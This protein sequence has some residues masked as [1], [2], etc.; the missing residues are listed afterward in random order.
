[1]AFW[2]Q[3]NRQ[4]L[5]LKHNLTVPPRVTFSVTQALD[6]DVWAKFCSTLVG[7]STKETFDT[8]PQTP[9]ITSENLVVVSIFK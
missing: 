1:M 2:L 6:T 4:S 9:A 5:F 8:L 3:L 7:V